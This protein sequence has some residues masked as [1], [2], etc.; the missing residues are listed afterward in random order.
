LLISIYASHDNAI[1][2][3][4]T[5]S[6][7]D[8]LPICTYRNFPLF[9]SQCSLLIGKLHPV[10]IFIFIVC[11]RHSASDHTIMLEQF[12]PTFNRRDRRRSEE[13]TSELQSRENLV[14][15]LLLEKKNNVK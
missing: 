7:H 4:N 3:I 12:I 6:L 5:L 10:F 2:L 11:F 8:A 14:C 15:L 1:S 9:G 13:H